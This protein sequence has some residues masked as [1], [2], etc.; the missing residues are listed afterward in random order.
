M[1]DKKTGRPSKLNHSTVSKLEEAFKLGA[2]V[3]EACRVSGLSRDTF[4]R[5]Y[6][7][8]QDFSDK[9][10]QARSWLL[11]LAKC[12]VATAIEKGDIKLSVWL[13]DKQSSLPL[14]SISDGMPDDEMSEENAKKRSEDLEKYVQARIRLH[15]H[16]AN[17][18]E[19]PE[20]AKNQDD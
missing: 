18:S 13:L 19:E 15:E 2:S 20:F 6:N 4:Y 7:S 8:N 9:M 11:V 14:D 17:Y 3:T 16:R 5:H 10:E 1:E 12:N